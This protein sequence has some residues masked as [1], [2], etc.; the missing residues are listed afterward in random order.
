MVIDFSW[1]TAVA[2]LQRHLVNKGALEYQ[3]R[4]MFDHSPG[5]SVAFENNRIGSAP[6]R[7]DSPL[8]VIGEEVQLE[9]EFVPVTQYMASGG[10]GIVLGIGEKVPV[11]LWRVDQINGR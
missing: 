2:E 7:C 9:F 4:Q 8:W 6:T 3:R 10:Y 11:V 1:M 5:Y